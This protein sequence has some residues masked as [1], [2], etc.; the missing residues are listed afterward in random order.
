MFVLHAGHEQILTGLATE[1]ANKGL[2][3]QC[4]VVAS[5]LRVVLQQY[6]NVAP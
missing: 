5:E 1:H 2:R 4:L 3:T 6:I